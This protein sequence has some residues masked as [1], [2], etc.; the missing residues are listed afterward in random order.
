MGNITFV[1]GGARSG[2]SNF[3]EKLAKELY[4]STVYIATAIPFDQEM[5]YRIKKHRERRPASWITIEKYNNFKELKENKD[6]TET[7]NIILDCLTVLVSN[8]MIQSELDWEN[9][10]PEQV[11]LLEKAILSD[12]VDLFDLTKDKNLIIV[13]NEVG[14]GIVPENILAFYYRDILGRI[15][16]LVA[17]KANNVFFLIA[18]IPLQIKGEK[19]EFI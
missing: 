7:E 6:F 3:A 9:I 11:S 1:L 18:G 5:K 16:Q 15:H 2:K 19:N 17:K 13:S 14:L 12:I 8:Q 4:G 10:S